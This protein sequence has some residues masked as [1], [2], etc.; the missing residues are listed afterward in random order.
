[1][2]VAATLQRISSKTQLPQNTNVN[3]YFGVSEQLLLTTGG[4]PLSTNPRKAAK[5]LFTAKHQVSHSTP[6]FHNS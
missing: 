6:M 3:K 4:K 2:K 1:M 5:S